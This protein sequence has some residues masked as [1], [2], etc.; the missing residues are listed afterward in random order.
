MKWFHHVL[1]TPCTTEI[2]F[3]LLWRRYT[4]RICFHQQTNDYS[5]SLMFTGLSYRWCLRPTSLQESTSLFKLCWRCMPKVRRHTWSWNKSGTS[6]FFYWLLQFTHHINFAS[7]FSISPNPQTHK[8]DLD[9][10]PSVITG[11]LLVVAI[12]CF[13]VSVVALH[14]QTEGFSS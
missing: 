8:L 10:Y 12:S 7:V 11:K 1:L 5:Y 2:I 9:W 6:T 3:H 4:V 14:H 13:F